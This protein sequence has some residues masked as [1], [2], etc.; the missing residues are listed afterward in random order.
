MKRV[1][2]IQ[3]T[4]MLVYPIRYKVVSISVIRYLQLLGY[5]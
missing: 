5:S 1:G 4:H 2:M 3:E